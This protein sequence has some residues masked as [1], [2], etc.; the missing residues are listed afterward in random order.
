MH[1]YSLLTLA[2][3]LGEWSVSC[4]MHVLPPGKAPTGWA[5]E[6]A[7]MQWSEEKSF[8]PARDR[9]LD[10]QSVVSHYTL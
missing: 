7:W 4:L 1:T 6:P 10:V 8:A 9:T 3:D 2:L 5:P